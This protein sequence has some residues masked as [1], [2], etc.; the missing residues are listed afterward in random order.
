[1]TLIPLRNSELSADSSVPHKQDTWMQAMFLISGDTF[2]KHQA[3]A[4]T[5]LETVKEEG[6]NSQPLLFNLWHCL[7]R[8]SYSWIQEVIENDFID[9]W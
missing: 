2:F 7:E 8:N 4:K 6:R 9:S 3:I 1:M 5:G